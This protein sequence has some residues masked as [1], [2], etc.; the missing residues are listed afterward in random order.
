MQKIWRTILS[1]SNKFTIGRG[2][3]FLLLLFLLLQLFWHPTPNRVHVTVSGLQQEKAYR[4]LQL[5]YQY[6]FPKLRGLKE[7]QSQLS[8]IHPTD[9]PLLVSFQLPGLQELGPVRLDFGR[10]DGRLKLHQ[11]DFHYQLGWLTY[12]LKTFQAEEILSVWMPNDGVELLD[13]SS[14]VLELQVQGI[15]PFALLPIPEKTWES[16]LPLK[17][18][19]TLRLLRMLLLLVGAGL[20]FCSY[21]FAQLQWVRRAGS[22][23][24]TL[25]N[26]FV[27][28]IFLSAIAFVGYMVYRPFLNYQ[29]LYIFSDVA[30]DTVAAFF[31]IYLHLAEYI[32]SEGWPMWSYSLGVGRGIFDLLLDPFTFLHMTLPPEKIAFGF[33]WIQYLKVIIAASLFYAWLRL[34]RIGRFGAVFAATGLA[35]SAHMIIRGNWLHYATEV[36]VVAFTLVAIELFLTK[37]FWQFVP[38]ALVL[39][40]IRGV[41]HTYVWT[42][43]LFGYVLC[44]LFLLYRTEIK[45][46]V[47]AM[48]KLIVLYCLGVMM[49]AAI[50]IPNLFAILSSA[51][52]GGGEGS[53]EGGGL[54]ATPL[55]ALNEP[56]QYLASLFGFFSPDMLGRADYYSGWGNYFEGP[57]LYTGLFCLLLLPQVLLKKDI[58]LRLV[59]ILFI[60]LGCAYIFVPWMRYFLNGFAGEYYKTSSFWISIFCA[61]LAA[62]ALDNL[63]RRRALNIWLLTATFLG[64]LG[65]LY[66][67]KFSPFVTTFICEGE[68]T[69][70]PFLVVVLLTCYYLCFLL[71]RFRRVRSYGLLLLLCLLFFE[72]FLFS[73]GVSQER[74]ALRG[75]TLETGGFYYDDS[76][77]AVQQLR[78][79]DDT[80]FRIEKSRATVSF[81]DALAQNYFGV[82][83]YN[84]FNSSAYLR[85]LG[86]KGFDVD[87]EHKIVGSTSYITGL[88]QRAILESL[89]S[90]K[91]YL[92]PEQ[93]QYSSLVPPNYRSIGQ[94]GT[95]QVFENENFIPFGVV[96]HNVIS[97]EFGRSI[98]T[99][100]R[101]LVALSAAFVAQDDIDG[102]GLAKYTDSKEESSRV[103]SLVTDEGGRR[104]YFSRKAKEL[105]DSAMVLSEFHQNSFAGSVTLTSAGLLFLSI[106]AEKGWSFF[107][108]NREVKPVRTHYGFYGVVLDAGV[109]EI[110]GEYFTPFLAPGIV[111]SLIGLLLYGVLLLSALRS[112]LLT[113]IVTPPPFNA[114]SS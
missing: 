9:S 47:E 113:S 10:G 44:R 88:D 70:A 24:T 1:L 94:V 42:I 3:L 15:D 32:R 98:T 83:S 61:C 34:L 71:V 17:D 93:E 106:P 80:F 40:I 89:L 74:M 60:V 25:W 14:G 64:L 111:I 91:Y 87:F 20:L 54:M 81:N 86:K 107:V 110:R 6:D 65:S 41:F 48:W 12:H 72:T 99:E 58:R 97:E 102:L 11:V 31:P 18:L 8:L 36:V 28:L 96:Y 21:K 37:R 51:R 101:E 19:I 63:V 26:R 59:T 39:L 76:M 112:N 79:R 85:F 53:V 56:R 108:N 92:S 29:L 82:K 49:A 4:S 78:G 46:R 95:Y 75:D 43:V 5:Y 22:G 90:V 33:G 84:S 104:A 30:N 109:S 100:Q 38:I 13:A 73:R 67:L 2:L 105:A 55:L 114:T 57:Q 23:R 52:V 7:R 69:N 62:L 27:P 77:T 16:A 50:L 68:N 45:K 66:L 103:G 35:F